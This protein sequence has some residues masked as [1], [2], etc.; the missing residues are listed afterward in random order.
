MLGEGS[1]NNTQRVAEPCAAKKHTPCGISCEESGRT[2]GMQGL[3]L[4]RVK[5][6]TQPGKAAPSDAVQLRLVK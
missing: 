2:T 1:L 3:G 5:P 4:H 6:D